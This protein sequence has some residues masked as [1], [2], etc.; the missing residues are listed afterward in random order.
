MFNVGLENWL[1][2]DS[3]YSKMMQIDS[4]QLIYVPYLEK[5]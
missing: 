2:I 3:N 1:T 4:D 5:Y